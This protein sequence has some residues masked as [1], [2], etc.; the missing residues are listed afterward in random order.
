MNRFQA[1]LDGR[2]VLLRP[3]DTS[4]YAALRMAELSGP[5]AYRWRLR[6]SHPSPERYGESLWAGVLTQFIVIRKVDRVPLGLVAAYNA[7][8]RDGF[9]HVGVAK[10]GDD[11]SALAFVGGVFIFFEYLF[12]GWPFRKLCFE[13][14]EYNVAQFDGAIGGLLTEEGRWSRHVFLDGIYWD[15]VLLSLWRETWEERRS[16]LLGRA[17]LT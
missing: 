9:V 17:G 2:T 14:P 15:L 8:H 6:G 13:A 16:A 7:D 12:R 3:V 5:L 11:V 4:D 1:F 10:F